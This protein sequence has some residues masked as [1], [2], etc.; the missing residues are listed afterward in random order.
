MG[1]KIATFYRV[2]L[3]AVST[4]ALVLSILSATSCQFLDYDHQFS[5]AAVSGTRRSRFL[6]DGDG[7][8]T[9]TDM[10][11][12]MG[13]DFSGSAQDENE[14]EIDVSGLGEGGPDETSALLDTA[15]PAPAPATTTASSLIPTFIK[16]SSSPVADDPLND[17]AAMI[18]AHSGGA[19]SS[20]NGTSE[21]GGLNATALGFGGDQDEG[22]DEGEAEGETGDSNAT[23][24]TPGSF[25]SSLP[26]SEPTGT[27]MEPSPSVPQQQQQQPSSSDSGILVQGSVGLFCNEEQTI[28]QIL[29]GSSSSSSESTTFTE[30]EKQKLQNLQDEIAAESSNE[31]SEELARN[32]AIAAF[33]FGAFIWLILFLECLFGGTMWCEKYVI[34]IL[35][36]AACICQGVTFLMFDSDRYCDGNI[37]H[38]ITNGEPCTVGK[39][40]AMSISALFLYFLTMIMACRV[41]NGEPYGLRRLCCKKKNDGRGGRGDAGRLP[42]SDEDDDGGAGGLMGGKGGDGNAAVSGRDSESPHW[43]SKDQHENE[44]I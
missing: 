22:G 14:I 26:A 31:E 37:I 17:L 11:T 15:A 40:A 25:P 7:D 23:T 35:G 29:F 16:I 41:P 19:G 44:V 34:G 27:G 3:V 28:S 13:N 8:V 6:Q 42:L 43:L 33:V 4:S 39:G 21:V 9:G 18:D 2:L 1:T 5:S 38:E 36:V 12:D 32:G 10:G 20:G 24:P 30:A